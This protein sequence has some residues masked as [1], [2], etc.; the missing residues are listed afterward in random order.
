MITLNKP[1][2]V[3]GI[4]I[5][6]SYFLIGL[7]TEVYDLRP[8]LVSRIDAASEE[9][10]NYEYIFLTENFTPVI[11]YMQAKIIADTTSCIVFANVLASKSFAL[12]V[13]PPFLGLFLYLAIVA[14]FS[15]Q[16][17]DRPVPYG[18]VCLILMFPT[19]ALSVG[20]HFKSTIGL[21]FLLMSLASNSRSRG[22][23]SMALAF[24]SHVTS[25]ISFIMYRIIDLK[26]VWMKWIMV[27]LFFF[28]CLALNFIFLDTGLDAGGSDFQTVL[29]VLLGLTLSINMRDKKNIYFNPFPLLVL[30][31]IGS[32]YI[33]GRAIVSA[34][35][36]LLA[37][38][39]LRSK[40]MWLIL[41]PSSLISLFFII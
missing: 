8:D 40:N 38:G 6:F 24:M 23:L 7:W 16:R 13:M 12:Y 2:L 33:G 28:F 1:A 21:L 11:L 36:L 29:V 4:F 18:T 9:C 35:P 17:P 41:A 20:E 30:I 37:Q 39:A 14:F 5:F 15:A 10:P 34:A 26:G 27:S 31:F 19:V 3:G 25:L 32:T 22:W